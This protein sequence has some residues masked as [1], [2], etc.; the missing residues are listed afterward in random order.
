MTAL[1]K[2]QQAV[3]SEADIYTQPMDRRIGEPSG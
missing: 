2:A 3:E 1:Q